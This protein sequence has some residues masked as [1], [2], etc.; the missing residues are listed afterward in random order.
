MSVFRTLRRK[1]SIATPRVAVRMHVPWYVRW[2]GMLLLATA[3]AAL[4]W[5]AYDFGRR[6]GG[7]DQS[8]SEQELVRAKESTAR[9]EAEVA[10]MRSELNAAE[11]RVKIEQATFGDLARQVKVLTLENAALK[12][13][14]A[15]F[16][17]LM[18]TGDPGKD[19]ITLSKY[20]VQPDALP[21]EYRYRLLFFQNGQRTR[22]FTG[23]VQFVLSVQQENRRFVLTLP[24]AAERNAN[25]YRLSFRAFQRLEGSFKVAPGVSV[26]S[27]QIRVN[28][29]GVRDPRITQTVNL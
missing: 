26:K 20:V 27:V 23:S 19:G 6:F 25:G 16:Q 2:V 17:A 15:F 29:D 28:E 10:H 13:D 7:F 18:K 12:E 1:F 5:T 8:E 21:G 4:G 3:V 11:Q 22:D 24:E 9:L 14:L